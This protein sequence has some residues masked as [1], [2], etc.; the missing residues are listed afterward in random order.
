MDRSDPD[1][2][3]NADLNPDWQPRE[4]PRRFRCDGCWNEVITTTDHTGAC[5]I[6]CRG[7]CYQ[8]VGEPGTRTPVPTRHIFMGEVT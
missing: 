3:H 8:I 6:L 7:L 5:H 4:A 2:L 1:F